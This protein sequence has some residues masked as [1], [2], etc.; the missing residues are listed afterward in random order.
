MPKTIK[1]LLKT[2]N[3]KDWIIEKKIFSK[4]NNKVKTFFFLTKEMRIF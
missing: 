1:G 2:R 4:E 3:I